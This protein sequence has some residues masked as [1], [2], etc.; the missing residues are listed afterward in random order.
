ML[1]AADYRNLL[2][3]VTW[4]QVYTNNFES[5]YPAVGALLTSPYKKRNSLLLFLKS[6]TESII[7]DDLRKFFID[8]RFEDPGTT[9]NEDEI[10]NPNQAGQVFISNSFKLLQENPIL[11]SSILPYEQFKQN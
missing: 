3:F 2:C 11:K 6:I 9:L 5:R 7:D 1:T 10:L 8:Q 4:H